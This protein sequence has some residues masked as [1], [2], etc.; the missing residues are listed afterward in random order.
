MTICP[1]AIAVGCRKCLVVSVCPLK[2]VIGDY[3]PVEKGPTT[4]RPENA[5]DKEHG[6]WPRKS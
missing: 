5:G 4:Q 1:V 6:S 3:R 2:S